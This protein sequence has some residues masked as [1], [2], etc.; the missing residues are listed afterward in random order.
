MFGSTFFLDNQLN[1]MHL[2]PAKSHPTWMQLREDIYRFIH[3]RAKIENQ[4]ELEGM[5]RVYPEDF[6]PYPGCFLKKD[7]DD[8]IGKSCQLLSEEYLAQGDRQ[9][10]EEA[11]NNITLAKTDALP[12]YDPFQNLCQLQK[13]WQELMEYTGKSEIRLRLKE[14]ID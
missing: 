5:T 12:K 7:L 11:L 3:E 13:R 10:A 2:S 9:G 4:R 6:D 1:I 8:K 14:F